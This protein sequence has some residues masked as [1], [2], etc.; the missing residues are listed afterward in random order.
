MSEKKALV[1]QVSDEYHRQIKTVAARKGLKLRE[2][3]LQAL[4]EC[5]G[6]HEYLEDSS[7]EDDHAPTQ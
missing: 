3:V 7:E 2:L 1:V 6:L 5:Y 4:E